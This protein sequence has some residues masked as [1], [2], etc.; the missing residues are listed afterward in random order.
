LKIWKKNIE[1]KSKLKKLVL[2]GFRINFNGSKKN[3]LINT[4]LKNKKRVFV[5]ICHPLIS[6]KFNFIELP[7]SIG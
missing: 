2:L 6:R 1:R 3:T 5:I 7:V 4:L